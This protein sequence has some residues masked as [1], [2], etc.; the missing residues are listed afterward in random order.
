LATITDKQNKASKNKL[1][2]V[3]I[4]VIILCLTGT[5]V[6]LNLFWMD[7]FQ[8]VRNRNAVPLG[9]I[10]FKYNTAQRRLSDRVLWDRLRRQSPVYN[11]DT[12]RTAD[13]S[14]ATI[15]FAGGREINLTENTL[16]RITMRDGM[17]EIDLSDGELS[18]GAGSTGVDGDTA[19]NIILSVGDKRVEAGADAVLS[20]AAGKDGVAF[21]VAEGNAVYSDS[22]GQR[23]TVAAGTAAFLGSGGED[24][25]VPS[26]LV[27]SPRLNA[28]Y[29][30]RRQESI[31]VTFTWTR[32]NLSA[33]EVLHLEIAEDRNFSRIRQT[34]YVSVNTAQVQLPPGTWYWRIKREAANSTLASSRVTVLYAP[35][36]SL[37]AP[38]Q[39]YTYQY[40]SK[41]PAV[42]FQWREVEGASQYRVE[43][44]NNRNFASPRIDLRAKGTVLDTSALAA[45]TWYWRITPVFSS[46]Y[47]GTA[48]S[49]SSSFNIEQSGTLTAPVLVGP[50]TESTVNIGP[51]QNGYF[52]WKKEREAASYT[53]QISQNRNMRNPVITTE[54]RN[55]FFVYRPES[56]N[57]KPGQYYWAVFQTASNGTQSPISEVFS[58]TVA[59]VAVAEA[60]PEAELEPVRQPD[61]PPNNYAIAESLLPDTRFTWKSDA[62]SASRFQVSSSSSF[63]QLVVDERVSGNV[64]QGRTLPPGTYYWR[65]TGAEPAQQTSAQQAPVRQF[66]VVSSLPVPALET[67]APGGQLVLR[68]GDQFTLRWRP[69]PRAERYRVRIYSGTG[70]R[71]RTVYEQTTNTPTLQVP[72]SALANGTYYWTVEAF[73]DGRANA[74]QLTGLTKEEQFTV[75]KLQPLTLDSPDTD[76]E[77]S[78]TVVLRWSTA[79]TVGQSRFVISQ[80]PNPLRGTPVLEIP[81]PGRAITL[82]P[83]QL[84]EGQYYWTVTAQTR[85]GLDISAVSPRRFRMAPHFLPKPAV[86]SPA[87]NMVI[88]PEELRANRSIIFNWEPVEG[89]TAYIFTLS[90]ETGQGRRQIVKTEPQQEPSWTLEDPQLLGEGDFVWQVEAVKQGAGTV[91]EER[92][93]VGEN[94]FRLNVPLPNQVQILETGTMYGK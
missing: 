70:L 4:V 41:T 51:G 7:L 65:I 54:T 15:R 37:I 27:T 22:G 33:A 6:S 84:K 81:N 57:L 68:S 88:G 67:P 61:F 42:R 69:V 72:A 18:L 75:R 40:F 62:S 23:R 77:V 74:T 79:E 34:I 50:E 53:I 45:G 86:L 47:Q 94:N 64:F 19:G 10:S 5:I 32:S 83:G 60:E 26:A 92:G 82:T 12:I 29:L 20:A 13:L 78:G 9:L 8:T 56:E 35:P 38:A 90:R 76:A 59:A 63:S 25:T 43:V 93:E 85:D 52:S 49:A 87:D 1:R 58:F 44:A 46:E 80:N 16:I 66:V 11:G 91:I 71:R 14:E 17:T 48:A 36:P 28:R 31:P 55:N 21:Q 2:T 30:N 39:G 89:A 3:D 73:A 24:R